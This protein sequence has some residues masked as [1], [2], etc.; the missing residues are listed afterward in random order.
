MRFVLATFWVVLLATLWGCGKTEIAAKPRTRVS[1]PPVPEPEVMAPAA[2]L[3][4]R[5]GGAVVALGSY[6][7]ELRPAVDGS[8]QAIV[9]E[10]S[11]GALL[12]PQAAQ[13]T[14]VVSTSSGPVAVPMKWDSKQMRFSGGLDGPAKLVSGPLEISLVAAGGHAQG[15]LNRVALLPERLH[16][17]TQLLAGDFGAEVAVSSSGEV[18]ALL[19]DRTGRVLAGDPK[20]S[21]TAEVAGSDDDPHAVKLSW[22]PQHERYR[23]MVGPDVQ[24]AAGPFNLSIAAGNVTHVGSL[25]FLPLR[26][27][28]RFGGIVVAAGDYSAEVLCRRNGRIEAVLLDSS[29]RP[30]AGEF[31]VSVDLLVA[32]RMRSLPLSWSNKRQ[33]YVGRLRGG[34]KLNPEVFRITLGQG[35]HRFGGGVYS[36]AELPVPR[37]NRWAKVTPGAQPQVTTPRK[38]V[39]RRNGRHEVD[40]SA[41]GKNE[42]QP[43]DAEPR[44]GSM[45]PR[46]ETATRSKRAAR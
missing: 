29:G 1:P 43:L 46:G 11:G 18:D 23:G 37:P 7:A 15:R 5:I 4:A 19:A 28:P 26:V 40:P 35:G 32:G 16:G 31:G 41:K 33:R 36:L 21:V 10:A 34:R 38:V 9:W 39:A 24:V 30:L 27:P 42:P 45:P 8:L 22:S 20:L 25:T 3:T 12:Q 14:L 13:L 2:P 6:G 17:G 44:L